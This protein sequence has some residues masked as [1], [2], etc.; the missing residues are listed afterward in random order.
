MKTSI[1][2]TEH[3]INPI[4]AR[5]RKTG[6]V[7]HYCRKVSPACGFCYAETGQFRFGT[8]VPY[9]PQGADE[10]EL[11]LD[12]QK[13]QEVMRRR[14]ST[15]YFWCDMTDMFYEDVP[16]TWIDA[17]FDV[18]R[19]TPRHTHQVLTKRPLRMAAYLEGRNVT[20][21]DNIWLGT[22]VEDQKRA[23]ER[24]PQ[25]LHCDAKVRFLS[26]EPIL[27]PIELPLDGIQWVIL[28]GES[29][30]HLFD[31][32]M[33]R[34]RGNMVRYGNGQW[35]PTAHGLEIARNIRDQCQAT[36]TA[37]FLKQWGGAYPR[38]AGRMLDGRT[39]DEMPLRT[40]EK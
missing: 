15:T 12:H 10:V 18:M 8:K 16:D 9:T 40:N 36:G 28:G 38:A 25:L 33:R 37:F 39:W 11:F 4:R 1:E 27:E 29:G 26:V 24:I 17:C 21:P 6:A 30:R 19:A 34:R 7:G 35:N 13:L 2:W 22:S 5:N 14:K 31:P 23:D 3:S 20:V 32:A